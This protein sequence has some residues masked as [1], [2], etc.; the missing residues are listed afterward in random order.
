MSRKS[1]ILLHTS[2]FVCKHNFDLYVVGTFDVHLKSMCLFKM[3]MS[4]L[5]TRG[6]M[7][8]FVYLLDPQTLFLIRGKRWFVYLVYICVRLDNNPWLLVISLFYVSA[9]SCLFSILTGNRL[10]E[11]C[12]HLIHGTTEGDSSTRVL[13]NILI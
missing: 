5:K 11:S 3:E 2:S 7:N 9:V 12:W 4:K 8:H 13:I 1:I 10:F 6:I